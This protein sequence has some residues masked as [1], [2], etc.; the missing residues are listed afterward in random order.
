M[1]THRAP[2]L[3]PSLLETST[4]TR[5]LKW[6]GAFT[7]GL[8]LCLGCMRVDPTH[9]YDPDSPPEFRAPAS[10]RAYVLIPSESSST[11][12]S[13]IRVRLLHQQYETIEYFID[14]QADG[15][16]DE[17]NLFPGDYLISAEGEIDGVSYVL[18]SRELFLPTGE[19]V[20]LR[21]PFALVPK[22]ESGIIR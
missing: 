2:S 11:N 16:V 17:I 8:S 22:S 4:S 21:A 1:K 5:I 9:P 13:A 6:L 10:L 20:E 15:Y 18:T 14:C 7:L 19:I 3:I 12:Y